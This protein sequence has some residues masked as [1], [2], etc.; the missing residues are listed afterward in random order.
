M[1]SNIPC[2]SLVGCHM[3]GMKQKHKQK[4]VSFDW[5][6]LC[7]ELMRKYA[8]EINV[9]CQRHEDER[10]EYSRRSY[11]IGF[12]CFNWMMTMLSLPS[13]PSIC[14]EI[15]KLKIITMVAIEVPRS[16]Y[17]PILYFGG[18]LFSIK[19]IFLINFE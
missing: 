3:W 4:P 7:I 11:I 15:S 12:V 16:H 6:I 14:F 17:K 19:L 2:G 5:N 10:I 9:P 8:N 1:C 18:K 13:D